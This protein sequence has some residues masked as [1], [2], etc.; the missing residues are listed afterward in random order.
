MENYQYARFLLE[1]GDYES[2]AQYYSQILVE[3]FSGHPQQLFD[4][5]RSLFDCFK[6]LTGKSDYSILKGFAQ[7]LRKE[8]VD[9]TDKKSYSNEMM[10]VVRLFNE[11]MQLAILVGASE[12]NKEKPE[13]KIALRNAQNIDRITGMVH[14]FLPWVTNLT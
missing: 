13:Y 4:V 8:F 10:Q 1:S 6:F 12:G 14:D 7:I 2:S 11:I 5:S 9:E 3:S